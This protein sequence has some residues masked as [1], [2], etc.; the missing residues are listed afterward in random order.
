VPSLPDQANIDFTLDERPFPGT[1]QPL[2]QHF[3]AGDVLGRVFEPGQEVERPTQ[4]P[5]VEEAA[6]DRGQV[7]DA[8]GDMR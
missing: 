3:E 4:V 7:L 2:H 8:D 1:A 5:A 6:S